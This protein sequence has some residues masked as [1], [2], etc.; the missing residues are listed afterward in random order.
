M[1]ASSPDPPGRVATGKTRDETLKNMYEAIQMHLEVQQES[2]KPI[3]D[4]PSS[5]V[6]LAVP[7]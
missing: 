6:Y 4:G 3:P 7:D 2:G 1:S 5:A